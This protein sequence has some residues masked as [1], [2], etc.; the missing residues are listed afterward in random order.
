MDEVQHV[1]V[2]SACKFK[3]P[4]LMH[5]S[6]H[7]PADNWNSEPDWDPN[8]PFPMP[9]PMPM[10]MHPGA[11]LH[12]DGHRRSMA[13]TVEFG[14][15]QPPWRSP[16]GK[17]KMAEGLHSSSSSS[18]ASSS[19][20]SP[21]IHPSTLAPN[22]Q[23]THSVARKAPPPL[24]TVSPARTNSSTSAGSNSAANHENLIVASNEE[25]PAN[26]GASMH[27]VR[28]TESGGLALLDAK[29]A[30]YGAH[31]PAEQR[32]YWTLPA[33]HDSRVL[34]LLNWVGRMSWAL[35]TLGV[36]HVSYPF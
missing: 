9:L 17:G 36:G 2:D 1:H 33:E 10:P 30:M 24:P 13:T 20:R 7:F 16:K 11:T 25:P 4:H 14:H 8:E 29:R 22:G 5:R 3:Q 19:I 28:V 15:R 35:A 34:G 6:P 32:F 26:D 18:A 27:A 31:R 21:S 12:D 23:L